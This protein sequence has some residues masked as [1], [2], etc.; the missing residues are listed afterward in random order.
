M[1]GM[2]ATEH[3]SVHFSNAVVIGLWSGDIES[4]LH[5][6]CGRDQRRDGQP[7]VS[8]RGEVHLRLVE[9]HQVLGTWTACSV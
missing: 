4:R 8:R 9:M 2:D 1:D 7:A 5:V 6:L 3:S